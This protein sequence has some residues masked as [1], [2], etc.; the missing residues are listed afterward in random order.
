MKT[1][2]LRTLIITAAL[3][4]VAGFAQ[5]APN[6]ASHSQYYDAGYNTAS[7]TTREAVRAAYLNAVKTGT[8]LELGGQD[9]FAK[10]PAVQTSSQLAKSR[11][12]VKNELKLA[13]AM[14]LRGEA[15][16]TF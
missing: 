11:T 15:A 14:P 3:S 10:A 1:S 7:N 13:Q 9:T 4:A 8:L 16:F 6:I 2:L 5:A 12:E